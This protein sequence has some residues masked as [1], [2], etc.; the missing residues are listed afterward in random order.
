MQYDVNDTRRPLAAGDLI[1]REDGEQYVVDRLLGSGGFALCYL[2]H[3]KEKSRYTVLK[4]LFPRRVEGGVAL[5][6]AD[7]RI[8]ICDPL[9]GPEDGDDEEAWQEEE[10]IFR[11]EADLAGKAARVY[12][13]RGNRVQQNH[14]DVLAVTGPFR[15]TRGNRYVAIDTAQGEP[16]KNLIERGFVRDARGAV[17]ENAGLGEI[18]A[19]L[20]KTARL[21]SRLHREN[22]LLHLDLSPEN[23]Y[24]TPMAGGTELMPRIL[25]HGSAYD[26]DDPGEERAHHYTCNPFSPPELMALADLNAPGAG[27]RPDESSDTYGLAAI[28]FYA[29][30]GLVYAPALA[31]D[32][33]WREALRREYTRVRHGEKDGK[34]FSELLI[35]VLEKGL[36]AGQRKR[37]RTAEE[38][39][40]ALRALREADRGDRG[41]LNGMD[42]DEL[43]A[44]LLL[45]KYPL[46]RYRNEAGEPEL[47]LAGDGDFALRLILT[48]VSCGQLPGVPLRI[49]TV[50]RESGEEFR[51][52]LLACAPL[53]ADYSDLAGPPKEEA[54]VTF[55][56]RCVPD[57]GAPGALEAALAA[58]PGCRWVLV[59]LGDDRANAEAARRIAGV[60]A[61]REDGR[62]GVVFRRASAEEDGAAS[63]EAPEEVSVSPVETV[64]FGAGFRAFRR[65]LRDLEGRTLRLHYLYDRLAD[66][67]ARMEASAEYL[68]APEN[69]YELRSSCAAALHVKY[70]LAA[71]GL[72]PEAGVTAQLAAD[73]RA[74]MEGPARGRLLQLE[75]RRWMMYMA[76]D[77]Y[78]LPTP[79][80]LRE[81]SFA[82]AGEEFNDSFR[83]TKRKLHP[84]LVPCG[85]AG[86]SLPRAREAWDRFDSF[87]SVDETD[88]DP[89]DR[90][91]L[92][93]HLLAGQ[94]LRDPRQVKQTLDDFENLLLRPLLEREEERK[95]MC[96]ANA[97][98]AEEDP[99]LAEARKRADEVL[100]ALKLLP[101]AGGAVI[102]PEALEPLEEAYRAAGIDAARG[103]GV[104]RQELAVCGE[105]ARYRDYK[106][107]DGA[108]AD[109]LLWL[110]RPE[111][112]A[113][114]VKLRSGDLLDNV[115][116]PLM[117]MPK[118][119]VYFGGD[120]DPR[121][122]EFFRGR[123]LR[124]GISFEPCFGES[125]QAVYEC[126]RALRS[127]LPGKCL[128]DLTGGDER[129]VCAATRL[130][131]EDPEVVLLRS[132]GRTQRLEPVGGEPG[133][134]PCSLPVSVTAEEVYSLYGARSR[135]VNNGYMRRLGRT[136]VELWDFY[137]EFRDDWELIT[138]FFAN[139][140]RGSAELRVYGAREDAASI[141]WRSYVR[142]VS[143]HTWSALG[144]D[145]AFRQMEAAGFIRALKTERRGLDGL[146][147]S[148][149]YASSAEQP[150]DDK[151]FRN[152]NY[153]FTRRLLFAQEPFRCRQGTDAAGTPVFHLESGS[154]VSIN[155]WTAP[156][157]PDK[158]QMYP[159]GWKR[160]P[161]AGV[162][163]ALHRLEEL[164]F[165]YD[166]KT[167]QQSAPAQCTSIEFSYAN[168]A[169]RDCL[170]NAGNVLELY[171]WYAALQSG[172]FDDCRANL[173]FR[174]EE[175]VEN[176]LDLILT[177]GLTTLV[178]SCKTAKFNK[179][180]LYEIRC[181]TDRF[182][183]NSRAVIIY[184]SSRAVDED[185]RL[186]DD[187]GPVKKRAE[188]MGVALIDMNE[189]P[190]GQLGQVLA[191]LA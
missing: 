75:H 65:E 32:R 40:D 16:L 53:L 45:E 112:A 144:L 101:E 173:A 115:L 107:P 49:H 176:E 21:L 120:R 164:G 126:L 177:K 8:V 85:A 88:W 27:Y 34:P 73:Y 36:A 10:R 72:D 84:C 129:S 118:L 51:R 140:G 154:L 149:L 80:E 39:C 111:E 185:G 64:P 166:V 98:P 190:D 91:S 50:G 47:L 180:H 83:D 26:L 178:V 97:D 2:A 182:S 141:S 3:R 89:L 5:R 23:V 95:A 82:Y 7:G 110:Y 68:A 104:L 131:M 25:D 138:A 18:L 146:S 69:L 157:F 108:M 175:G 33:S 121:L 171:A 133:A 189:V 76:A 9:T 186:T 162:F 86:I 181:L 74:A 38:L 161:Y 163:P 134:A 79:E 96:L 56:H 170:V 128:V 4:E 132:D 143:R 153:F 156:D 119:L 105:F 142:Q 139:R 135:H 106:A 44:C 17:T 14:P 155:D 172:E 169:V 125:V 77:G 87:A 92:K 24:L 15:D 57:P 122:E 19:V 54:W 28:L 81:Y 22:R 46:C 66:P 145:E 100:E 71:L 151:T 123:G 93:L 31:F 1:V 130:Q 127:R 165:L 117:L 159:G 136:A 109:H 160:F 103:F 114:L 58:C 116:S 37:Y 187:L 62:S 90:M 67:R 29:V 52:R 191:S 35:A 94:K 43:T 152:L 150:G 188:A 99:R 11:R 59:S 6:R 148:F 179:S 55:D 42:P 70:K 137:R 174:W 60:L 124:T 12:D 13:A 48:A 113:V 61:A 168:L 20:E 183:L 184:S 167:S 147:L 158:R 78:R 41:L 30:T 102:R 63:G